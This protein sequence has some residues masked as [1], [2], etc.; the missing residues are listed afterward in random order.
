MVSHLTTG[1]YN[2]SVMQTIEKNLVP[3]LCA[4]TRQLGLAVVA[5]VFLPLGNAARGADRPAW[6][7]GPALQQNLAASVDI[8]WAEN[9]LRQAVQN[10]SQARRVAVLVDRRVDPGQKLNLSLRDV[11]LESA[12]QTIAKS[13]DL[14][15][16]RLG[17][18]IYLGPPSSA[19]RL[20]AVA[21]AFEKELLHQ[22]P[23]VK[24]TYRQTRRLLWADFAA[25][26]DLLAQLAAENGLEIANLDAVPH[27]LWAEADLPPLS[28]V[29][30]LTLIAVQ[31]DLMFN[32]SDRGVRLELV[33]IP[34]EL[35]RLSKNT[36]AAVAPR[37]P[38]KPAAGSALPPIARVSVQEKPLGPVLEQLAKQLH[39]EL[40]IDRQAI[41]A[42]GVSLDQRVSLQVENVSVD[43]LLERLL[44]SS[45]LKFERRQRVV[46]ISPK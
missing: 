44:E 3:T 12:L 37:H 31:F 11:S 40:K 36:R 19:E 41:A 9:P 34:K 20:G 4:G 8:L 21:A 17:S 29:D 32:V 16:A 15:M 24:R 5:A 39:L 7:T 1:G 33:P 25:P 22:P 26:R 30:R 6:A 45:G 2:S 14:G 27:D 10:L 43:E 18:V 46:E 42:A 35:P 28:L 13:R 38:P 23:A